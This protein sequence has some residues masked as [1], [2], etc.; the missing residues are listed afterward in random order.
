[1]KSKI[2]SLF[3]LLLI[4]LSPAVVSAQKN[5]AGLKKLF[6]GLYENHLSNSSKSLEDSEFRNLF[7]PDFVGSQVE[8]ALEGEANF[9]Q[10]DFNTFKESYE[11]YRVS[12][13]VGIQFKINNYNKVVIKGKTGVVNLDMSFE[14]KKNGNVLSKGEYTVSATALLVNDKDWRLTFLNSVYVQ[15]EVFKG[16]CLCELYKQG[17]KSFATFLTVPDGNKYETRTDRFK[18]TE[19]G[20]K[21]FIEMNSAEQYI[22][23]TKKKS[24][25]IGDKEIASQVSQPSTAIANI[26]RHLNAEKCQ[27]V[28]INN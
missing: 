11:I 4:A 22:L 21:V 9:K 8:I 10:L 27:N 13:G 23:D 16:A 25:T 24:V 17:D 18:V 5:E 12:S 6:S 1:M 3:S 15:G 14:I 26:L 20:N 28:E 7:A 19:K 2:I